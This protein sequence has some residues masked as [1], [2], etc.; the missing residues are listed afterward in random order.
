LARPARLEPATP[1]LLDL[2]RVAIGSEALRR[3]RCLL[4]RVEN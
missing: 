1:G 4:L 3:S 2:M